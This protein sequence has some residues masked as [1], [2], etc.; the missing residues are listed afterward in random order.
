MPISSACSQPS[1]ALS[2][3]VDRSQCTQLDEAALERQQRVEQEA[4]RGQRRR[5]DKADR[6]QAIQALALRPILL[7]TNIGRGIR[8]G[9]NLQP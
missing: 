2:W 5:R 6:Q 1:S 8:L 3:L 7:D 9:R 4:Q